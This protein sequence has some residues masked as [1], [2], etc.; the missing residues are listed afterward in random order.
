MN[1]KQFSVAPMLDWTTKYCRYFHRLITKKT[2]LYTEMITTGAIIHGDTER[3]L[4]FF[5]EEGAVS[6]QLGGSDPK[7][8]AQSA[9]LG[10]EFGYSEINLNIGCPSDRV[11]NGMFGACLMA[12]PELVADGV[13]AM[14]EAVDIPVTVKHRIGI[15]DMDSFEELTHFI[16]VIS[17]AGCKTF[18]VHARKAWLSGLSP[19][20]NRDVPPL[21]YETVYQLKKDFPDINFMI[22]GGIKS[23]EET[24]QH[25]QQT[26]G[27]MMGRE[28]YHNPWLL[29][30]I[31]EKVYGKE[32]SVL[33]R[34][35]VVKELLPFIEEQ[36]QKDV[37][38][39]HISRHLLGLFHGQPGAK[40]WRRSISENA[41]KEGAGP[42]V[43]E[44]A[45]KF[46]M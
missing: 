31:D 41:H 15:D 45:L 30:E 28:A 9:K 35:D 37:Y 12:T 17:K 36:R 19:K 7:A 46:V 29:N 23:L 42:E 18:I 44:A 24:Q 32:K 21:N 5:P 10:E 33:T 4:N 38:L 3:H 20:Q 40:L 14:I 8:L 22:N 26:D 25:N 13:S 11:Q 34:Y 2:L 16:D 1:N 6:L 39:N 43:I 27:V